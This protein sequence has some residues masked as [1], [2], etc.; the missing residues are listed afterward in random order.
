MNFASFCLHCQSTKQWV[1]CTGNSLFFIKQTL[2]KIV[3][4]ALL[5]VKSKSFKR[6]KS[7][8]NQKS[9]PRAVACFAYMNVRL[10]MKVVKC[11]THKEVKSGNRNIDCIQKKLEQMWTF[12]Y[13][14]YFQKYLLGEMCIIGAKKF[15]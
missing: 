6:V 12:S 13:H 2:L 14:Y 3:W 11:F 10:S 8:Q 9:S 15:Q 5:C 7:L 4:F 1:A